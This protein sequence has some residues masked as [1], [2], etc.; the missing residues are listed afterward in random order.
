MTI[1][2]I[3][4]TNGAGKDSVAEMLAARHGFLFA[5]ATD[6]FV[7]E[8]TKR[9][10]PLDREHKANLSAEWRRESGTGVIVDK[11]VEM[12]NNSDHTFTG[13]I[14]GSLRHPGEAD[15][16]HELGGK[17]IWVDADPKVRYARITKN[18]ASRGRAAEDNKS[19]QEFLAE[20]KREMTPEGDYA[21]LNIQAVKK[22]CDIFLTNNGNDIAVFQAQA[23]KILGLKS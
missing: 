20:E 14:V 3:A 7:T 11:A 5:S 4:G 12:F 6:M 22:L 15:K 21:T 2:G 8:L 9:G 19:F 16:I 10:L 1:Y 17:V 23:E 18:A 13:L